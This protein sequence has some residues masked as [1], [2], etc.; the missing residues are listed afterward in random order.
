MIGKLLLPLVLQILGVGVI[1]V[2]FI[3]PTAGILS[4]VALG[5]FGFSLYWVFTHFPVSVGVAFVVADLI[6]IPVLVI[7]GAR[8]LAA[9]RATLRDTLDSKDGA[10]SQPPE[11]S[12]VQDKEGVTV[13]VL[14]PAGSAMID[15]K[16]YDVV[17]KGDFIDKGTSI[18]VV[19]VEGNRIVV[20]KN[21]AS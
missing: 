21:V 2:E 11:W 10:V 5:I 20:K 1:L 6:I 15:G 19:A 4:I 17:S 14:R 7:V 8:M 16:K 18:V 13:S 3:V 12:Q 9:S